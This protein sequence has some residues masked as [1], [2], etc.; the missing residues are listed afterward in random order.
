M[1][2]SFRQIRVFE[3]ATHKFISSK[4]FFPLIK[5]LFFHLNFFLGHSQV[6]NCYCGFNLKIDGCE[7]KLTTPS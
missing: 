3:H 5:K 2:K 6:S 4:I 7:L 1:I